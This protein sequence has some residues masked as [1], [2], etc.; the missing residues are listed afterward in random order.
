MSST[1]DE[2]LSLLT[3]PAA[4]LKALRQ[5]LRGIVVM[6]I[7][8]TVIGVLALE[9][10]AT[11]KLCVQIRE[12]GVA[13][14]AVCYPPWATFV[15]AWSALVLAFAITLMWLRD[16]ARHE[17][18]YKNKLVDSLMRVRVPL[19]ITVA[20]VALAVHMMI[21]TGVSERFQIILMGVVSVLAY[22][23]SYTVA[24]VSKLMIVFALLGRI[25]PSL[26]M[27][28]ATE[29]TREAD[30]STRFL[31]SFT[32]YMCWSLSSTLIF[33]L[34]RLRQVDLFSNLRSA[35]LTSDGKTPVVSD[36]ADAARKFAESP[37][38]GLLMHLVN[39]FNMNVFAIVPPP[40]GRFTTRVEQV[41]S[42]RSNVTRR[43]GIV[44]AAFLVG[45]VCVGTA[46]RFGW[47][48]ELHVDH[49]MVYYV[50]ATEIS[51][52]IWPYGVYLFT[53]A[54]AAPAVVC[55]VT[56][57]L[58]HGFKSMGDAP[59]HWMANRITPPYLM[60]FALQDAFLY[61]ALAPV[62]GIVEWVTALFGAT[63]IGMTD[64]QSTH[65]LRDDQW[66]S[67]VLAPGGVVA[68]YVIAGISLETS[69]TLANT[70]T[71]ALFYTIAGM[72]AARHAVWGCIR[73]RRSFSTAEKPGQM[74]WMSF[75]YGLVFAT[76]LVL[77][78]VVTSLV[79]ATGV[80]LPPSAT[81]TP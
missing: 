29:V 17:A 39:M 33:V 49:E 14:D 75:E 66:L 59:F 73:W 48:K 69:G 31:A 76:Q 6:I 72:Y 42:Y 34:G 10:D 37:L 53:F 55:L 21:V 9:A 41:D 54:W 16:P 15:A 80:Y 46:A 43:L 56:L 70:D 1:E 74:T 79:F 26:M 4:R 5:L 57:V 18:A 28:A 67:H 52:R 20:E 13:K 40:P 62:F 36:V 30:L 38:G 77:M 3:A 23:M 58:V 7:V 8:V 27:I 81:V 35:V 64:V 44:I 47:G 2:A 45:S 25:M 12:A 65:V 51:R 68:A 32:L 71:R 11:T 60:M 19:L 22:W 63:A 61:L 24:R 78:I 50:G